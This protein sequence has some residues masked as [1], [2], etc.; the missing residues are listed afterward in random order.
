[1]SL[2]YII[3]KLENDP[4][5]EKLTKKLLFVKNITKYLFWLYNKL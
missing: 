2:T 5:V 4:L 1:M 3:T